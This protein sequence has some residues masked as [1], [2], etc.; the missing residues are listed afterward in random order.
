MGSILFYKLGKVTSSGY[1]GIYLFRDEESCKGS[2][3]AI[4]YFNIVMIKVRIPKGSRIRV[5]KG[6]RIN[7]TRVI[8][9]NI[10]AVNV[11]PR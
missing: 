8:P 7:A 5:A 4:G 10:H 11:T 2:S 1:P 9:L 6:R 3:S